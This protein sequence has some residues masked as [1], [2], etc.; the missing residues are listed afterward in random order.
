MCAECGREHE[1]EGGKWGSSR[2][3]EK[4]I[5]SRVTSCPLWEVVKEGKLNP[6]GCAGIVWERMCLKF[7]RCTSLV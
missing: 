1:A 6:G 4:E 7:L 2:G 5:L 3:G